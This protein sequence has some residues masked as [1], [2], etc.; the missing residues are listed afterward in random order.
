MIQKKK[1]QIKI[2]IIALLILILTAG[3]TIWIV[4]LNRNNNIESSLEKQEEVDFKTKSLLLK[5]TYEIEDTYGAIRIEELMENMYVLEYET[6]EQTQRAYQ[7][8]K[9]DDKIEYI[10]PDQEYETKN[11]IDKKI[12]YY[13]DIN[14]EIFASWAGT[15]MGLDILQDK[16]NQK[17]EVPTITIAVLDSGL[18]LNHIVITEKYLSN[19]SENRYNAIDRG[20]DITDENGHGTFMTGAILDCAPNN[21]SIIPVKL[22]NEEGQ[23]EGQYIIRAINYAIEQNVDI[24]NMSL[25]TQPGSSASGSEIAL[26]DAIETAIDKGI[27]VV[28]ATGNGDEN[29]IAYNT[30]ILGNEVYPAAIPDVIAVGSVK[31]NLL[32][33]DEEGQIVNT[34]E[35]YKKPT[36]TDLT[37]STF[38]N[39]GSTTD[40]V[41]PGENIIGISPENLSSTGPIISSGTSQATAHMSA[42]IANILSYNK[43]F[44]NEQ[45]YEILE[46]YAEDL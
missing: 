18:D 34:F 4:N 21:I 31:N 14:G 13:K 36:M 26:Q 9:K 41:A 11:D 44:T 22:L 40:F 42:A 10:V 19:I 12:I 38:S 25:G 35:T 1:K 5:T 46:Y 17:T 3:G 32:E 45:V 37:I 39:Y 28:A 29:G 30:D 15:S 6:E 23:A 20:T 27:I 24:I 2:I 33:I 43:E 8:L 16:I 7:E